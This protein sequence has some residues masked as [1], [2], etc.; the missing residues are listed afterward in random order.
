MSGKFFSY[1]IMTMGFSAFSKKN[2]NKISFIFY[3]EKKA[4]EKA[5]KMLISNLL[6]TIEKYVQ[7]LKGKQ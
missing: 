2:L 1:K 5:V 7:C 6:I 4:Y 3:I